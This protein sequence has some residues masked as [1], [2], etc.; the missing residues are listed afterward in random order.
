MTEAMAPRLAG[1]GTSMA[2]ATP[3]AMAVPLLAAICKADQRRAFFAALSLSSSVF[4]SSLASCW[5][6]CATEPND[7]C[8]DDEMLSIVWAFSLY[9]CE[10]LYKAFERRSN[11]S[12]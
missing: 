3:L 9:D 4:A 12:R 5:Y 6:I 7:D 1:H 8:N 2:D 11:V 10:K